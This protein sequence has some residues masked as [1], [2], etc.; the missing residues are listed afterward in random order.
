VEED[1]I[2]EEVSDETIVVAAEAATVAALVAAE[3]LA[4]AEDL[5]MLQE[6]CTKL[7]ALNAV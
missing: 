2:Q 7:H 6:K 1:E 3:I 4:V 5:T